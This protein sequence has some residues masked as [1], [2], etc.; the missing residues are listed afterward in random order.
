ME[1]RK[2]KVYDNATKKFKAIK[3]NESTEKLI[4]KLLG[5]NEVGKRQL[6]VRRQ[7][8][9]SFFRKKVREKHKNRC[10]K[11]RTD[12]KIPYITKK[13]KKKNNPLVMH[14]IGYDWDCPH[15]KG[16]N[17]DCVSCYNKNRISF[18]ICLNNCI[19]LCD[20]CHYKLHL[21]L[22][23]ETGNWLH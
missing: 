5:D 20:M 17:F 1:E 6:R 11:C 7:F 23:K 8:K 16:L 21:N 19:L 14:H 3:V 10:A 9:N 15:E 4:D 18:D 22:K 12:G 13:G 2:M